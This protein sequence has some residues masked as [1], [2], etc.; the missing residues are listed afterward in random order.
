MICRLLFH[1]YKQF[2][3]LRGTNPLSR[4]IKNKIMGWDA[5]IGKIKHVLSSVIGEKGFFLF[6][7]IGSKILS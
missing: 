2:S 3:R 7:E 4:A 1:D 6:Y 5:I